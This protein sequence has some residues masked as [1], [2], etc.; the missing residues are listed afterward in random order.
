M[1]GRKIKVFFTV[2]LFLYFFSIA[3]LIAQEK[4]K[5][6]LAGPVAKE[7]I[8][9]RVA[10]AEIVKATVIILSEVSGPA[11][12]QEKPLAVRVRPSTGGEGAAPA[13]KTQFDVIL[14]S[15][16]VTDKDGEF[17]L[18]I[19]EEQFRRIPA[20]A[21][22][23]LKLKIRPPIEFGYTSDEATVRLKQEQGPTYE[24]ILFWKSVDTKSNKGTFAVSAKAQT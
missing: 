17:T 3:A 11:A 1:G 6:A 13:E 22:F 23:D 2:V 16:V 21:D 5:A 24:L 14:K 7:E 4:P 12:T 8:K 20:R 19:P 10:G 9:V 15:R 18:R